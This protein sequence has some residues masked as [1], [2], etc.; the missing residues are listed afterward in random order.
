MIWTIAQKEFLEKILDFRVIISFVIAIGLTII[1]TIVAGGDYNIKK[2]EYD[3]ESAQSQSLLNNVKV[4]S[5]YHPVVYYRPS[6]LS[7]FSKGIDIPT[8]I[9]VP[10]SIDEVPLYQ[11]RTAGSNPMMTIFDTLDITMVVQ[12][13]FSLLVILLTFD[14]FSGEREQGTL[15]LA[16]SNPVARMNLLY[17]KF[18]GTIMILGV[19]VFL[20]YLIT[21]LSLRFSMGFILTPEYFIRIFGMAFTTLIYLGLFA[22]LGIYCSI[23]LRSSSTSLALLLFIWFFLTLLQPNLNIYIASELESKQ[24][25]FSIRSALNNYTCDAQSDLERLQKD[26][27]NILHD[28]SKQKYSEGSLMISST[29]S[30]PIVMFTAVG[31]ADYDI[32]NYTMQQV[33]L[34]RGLGSCADKQYDLAK[35]LYIDHLDKQVGWKRSLDYL[36]PAGIFA[37]SIAILS[38]TDID[39]IDEFFSEAQ[40]FR[41][42]YVSYLDG[43]GVFTKDPQLFFTRLSKDQIDPMATQARFA[44]Y[45]KDPKLIPMISE[46]SSLNMKDAPTFRP[47]ESETATDVL[48]A[49]QTL[50]PILF[51]FV[52]V[53]FLSGRSIKTYDPR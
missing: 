4:Y 30:E 21:L 52:I 36:S 16:L 37:H 27:R 31:D 12:V 24:W 11:P 40:K 18:I 25:I 8:P 46:Q 39:N 32:L 10:I 13:L 38:R 47:E 14:S 1:A 2:I 19:V 23:K 20:T 42:Q 6:P 49:A 35:N 53:F 5:Q 34:Y 9:T 7:V 50:W 45:K 41:N 44:G 51:C 3:K 29:G 28:N 22:A 26:N 15:R 33:R 17:G 43:K 48:K